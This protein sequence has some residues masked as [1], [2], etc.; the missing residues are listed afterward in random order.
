MLLY[1]VGLHIFILPR[2]PCRP[3]DPLSYLFFASDRLY[4]YLPPPLPDFRLTPGG[5]GGGN[6][7]PHSPPCPRMYH[8]GW[9]SQGGRDVGGSRADRPGPRRSFQKIWKKSIFH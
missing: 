8:Q 7:P 5:W 1:T 6:S 3:S 4:C 9:A 2:T